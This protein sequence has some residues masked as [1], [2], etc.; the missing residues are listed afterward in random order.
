VSV[1]LIYWKSFGIQGCYFCHLVTTMDVGCCSAVIVDAW[2]D[3]NGCAM[4]TVLLLVPS[5]LL[6]SFR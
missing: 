3:K 6:D 5:E 2:A 4:R 1:V